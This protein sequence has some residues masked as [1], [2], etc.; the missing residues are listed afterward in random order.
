METIQKFDIISNKI[1]ESCIENYK[2]LSNHKS[3]VMNKANPEFALSQLNELLSD[4]LKNL[5]NKDFV[6]SSGNYYKHTDPYLPHT[7]YKKYENNILNVVIPLFNDNK[8]A[9]LIIFDQLWNLDSVTWCM[10]H[11]VL[12]FESNIGVKGCPY[13]YPID[14]LT[15]KDINN[16]FYLKYL[17]H[18]K[19]DHLFGLSGT[20]YPYTPGSIIIFDTRK[21][22]CTSSINKEKIGITLRFREKYD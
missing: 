9:H 1:L 22:H 7:D 2:S 18:Y 20:A 5:F 11:P 16:E 19:K 6:Y 15:Y 17:N 10:H 8:D 13:E 12:Y 21:I 4:I 3:I 14:K